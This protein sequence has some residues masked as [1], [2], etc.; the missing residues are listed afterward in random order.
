MAE[1]GVEVLQHLLLVKHWDNSIG[2]VGE[3]HFVSSD[4]EEDMG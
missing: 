2:A 1:M 4:E 3:E